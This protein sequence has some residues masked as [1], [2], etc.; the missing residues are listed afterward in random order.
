MGSSDIFTYLIPVNYKLTIAQLTRLIGAMTLEEFMNLL[1]TTRYKFFAANLRNGT[2]EQEYTRIIDK[3]FLYNMTRYP[4]SMT[5]VNY[6]LF[7]KDNE[8]RRLTTAV[9]CIRYGL[10][11]KKKQEYLLQP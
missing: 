11:Q 5:T 7:R 2:M 8:I 6:Y 1:S 3:I 4:A 10:D 9:E